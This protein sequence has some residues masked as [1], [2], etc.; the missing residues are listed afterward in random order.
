MTLVRGSGDAT[1]DNYAEINSAT[2]PSGNP[3]TD[4][5]STPDSNPGNDNPVTP[6][7][8]DDNNINGGG[9]SVG[10][11]E[12]DHDPAAPSIIDVALRKTTIT[13]GPYVYG[14]TVSFNIDVINQGN[15]TVT[16]V[17]VVDYIP[18]GFEYVGG[19][20]AWSISGGQ[21]TAMLAGALVPGQTKSFTN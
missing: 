17:S 8:P 10:Q 7:D 12:D 2:D 14:Q 20:Q 11:D 15:V 6:G 5:D 16:D 13:A 19:S 3:V 21:A 1:W 4:A 9:P 18:C